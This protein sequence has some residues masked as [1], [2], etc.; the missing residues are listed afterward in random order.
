SLFAYASLADEDGKAV[1]QVA[2]QSPRVSGLE[3]AWDHNAPTRIDYSVQNGRL[4][5]LG[6][7]VRLT[8]PEIYGR[9]DGAVSITLDQ[10]T[11]VFEGGLAVQGARMYVS[12]LGEEIS[13]F[14]AVAR[15][16]RTGTF[17]IEEA[18]GKMGA[19]AFRASASGRMKGLEFDSGEATILVPKDAVPLS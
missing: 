5:L 14:D 8:I 3:V 15:F 4:A 9:V 7:I 18:T 11:Q 17:R 12:A 16:D 19:G 6:P 13:S 2:C 1:F 10:C